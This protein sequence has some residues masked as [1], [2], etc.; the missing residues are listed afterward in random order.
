M[1]EEPHAR[2]RDMPGKPGA[3][4]A[5]P[6]FVGRGPTLCRRALHGFGELPLHVAP[7]LLQRHYKSVVALPGSRLSSGVFKTGI[8]NIDRLH[9]ETLRGKNG[10]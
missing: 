7:Q 2:S 10:W 4:K 8:P 1:P 3:Q 6:S 9:L 5:R